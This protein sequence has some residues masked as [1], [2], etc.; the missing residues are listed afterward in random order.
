MSGPANI[1]LAVLVAGAVALGALGFAGFGE[2]TANGLLFAAWTLALLALFALALRLPLRGSG[3]RLSA[4]ITTVLVTAAAVAIVIAANVALFRHDVHYDVSR[5]GRNTPPSQLTTVID[6]LRTP[7]SLTYFYNAG[8]VNALSAK[9]LISIAARGHPQ[10]SFHAIDLDKEPGL[11]R[12]IGVR[13]YN[14]AVLQAGDRKVLVENTTDPTR[15][16]YAALR[17]LKERVEIVCFV[18]GHGETFRSTE[19]HFHYS[20][21]ETLKGHEVQGAGDV[22][23]AAPEQ[24]DRLQLALTEIGYEMRGIV[25]ADGGAVP[26][27]CAVVAEI[28]PRN[29]LAP[30]EADVLVKYVAGGGRLLLVLDPL[31]PVG[32]DLDKHLLGAVGLATEAAIVIDPLNHFRTDPDKVAVPYYPPHPITARVALTVFPQVRPIH[33]APPPSG[34]STSILATSSQD[35]YRRPPSAAGDLAPAA[36]PTAPDA[37]DRGAQVLAVAVEGVWPGAATDK[38]FRL[39]LAGTSKFA[40]NEYFPYVSNG[41]LAVSMVRWLATDETTPGVTPQTYQLPE[42]VLTSRQMR[43]LFIALEVLLPLSTMLCGVLVWWRRR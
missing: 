32:A 28:G 18:T 22:L 31:S 26:S 10:F 12:D 20:H 11:A 3:S 14:T 13:A 40:S 5:E 27:D 6:N 9:D 30:G 7:L 1:V 34:V 2:D 37:E 29:A 42:V 21:V 17:A 43:D 36:Q 39:V 35:S 8:D 16:A 38:H 23:V 41:E 4:W 33:V 19:A 25:T 15:L 24:L